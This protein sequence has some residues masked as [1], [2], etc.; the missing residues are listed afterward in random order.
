MAIWA[1]SAAAFWLS[2]A[3]PEVLCAAWATPM[4]FWAISALALAASVRFR[5]ISYAVFCL[6]KKTSS[7]LANRDF[8]RSDQGDALR[9]AAPLPRPS[10]PA[11]GPRRTVL[12]LHFG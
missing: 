5:L 8:G 12:P 3:P 6:K 7:A 4:M 11:R 9:A 1:N 10:V 2:P